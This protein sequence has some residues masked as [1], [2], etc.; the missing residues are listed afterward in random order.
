MPLFIC[1]CALNCLLFFY[2]RRATYCA[3]DCAHACVYMRSVRTSSCVSLTWPLACTWVG[4]P[5]SSVWFRSCEHACS[6]CTGPSGGQ[7]ACK[8]WCP[9]A[10]VGHSRWVGG[11]PIGG[12]VVGAGLS[13]GKCYSISGS[14]GSEHKIINRVF[15]AVRLCWWAWAFQQDQSSDWWFPCAEGGV[16]GGGAH[17]TV[18]TVDMARLTERLLPSLSSPRVTHWQSPVLCQPTDLCVQTQHGILSHPASTWGRKSLQNLCKVSHL[19]TKQPSVV[20]QDFDSDVAESWLELRSMTSPFSKWV[21]FTSRKSKDKKK[22]QKEPQM[23]NNRSNKT[24]CS[25]TT[26]SLVVKSWFQ[27]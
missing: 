18:E 12:Q 25:C 24:M 7:L 20:S 27:I 3:L 17:Q 6:V 4:V 10:N 2:R 11:A 26:A 15:I 8:S 14:V 9:H 21:L 5:L 1:A 16:V 19:M 22:E 13:W 23:W